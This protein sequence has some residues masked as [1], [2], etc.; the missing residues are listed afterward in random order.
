MK[1]SNATLL[2][3]L[4]ALT[5][6]ASF[7][8]AKTDKRQLKDVQLKIPQQIPARRLCTDDADDCVETCPIDYDLD[9]KKRYCRYKRA[10]CPP[11]YIRRQ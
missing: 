3:I 9:P 2:A 8:T 10:S 7:S 1:A 4:L 11:N 6:C 5:T